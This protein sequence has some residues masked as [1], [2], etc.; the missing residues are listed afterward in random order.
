MLTTVA[1]LTADDDDLD[2]EAIRVRQLVAHNLRLARKMLGLSQEALAEQMGIDVTSV[3]RWE[4]GRRRPEAR[5]MALLA[6]H[7]KQPLPFFVDAHPDLDELY[8]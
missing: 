7:L 3:S 6:R 8:R 1:N 2:G 4:N 5:S